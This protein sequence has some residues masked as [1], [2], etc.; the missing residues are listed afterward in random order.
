[1]AGGSRR[2][3]GTRDRQ[4]Q[5]PPHRCSLVGPR[6][7]AAPGALLCPSPRQHPPTH[8]P[9]HQQRRG[10]HQGAS[11]RDAAP[12]AARTRGNE[13]QDVRR[14]RA[15]DAACH[16]RHIPCKATSAGPMCASPLHGTRARGLQR[17]C[18]APGF[19]AGCCCTWFKVG[20]SR[21]AGNE[22]GV[23]G[24]RMLTHRLNRRKGSGGARMCR[25]LH[26]GVGWVGVLVQ[27]ERCS[28]GKLS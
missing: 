5:P 13:R 8:P 18:S 16:S 28:H 3:G 10:G 9:T 14:T 15:V 1:M 12:H 26:A 24:G 23:C 4:A 20:A 19:A 7:S 22:E 25:G 2:R 17:G 21:Q 6:P 27:T 11:E